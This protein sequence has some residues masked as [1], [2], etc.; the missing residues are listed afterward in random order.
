MLPPEL[1]RNKATVKCLFTRFKDTFFCEK[2][3]KG[4]L[5]TMPVFE[6]GVYS[7][8]MQT[9]HQVDPPG[10]LEGRLGGFDPAVTFT[11]TPE[12]E[13]NPYL[14]QVGMDSQANSSNIVLR[15]HD[16]VRNQMVA[17][18]HTGTSYLS[19]DTSSETGPDTK[20]RML[21]FS[22]MYYPFAQK[23]VSQ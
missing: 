2:I 20:P 3:R 17:R 14:V 18:I 16:A 19:T 8:D 12:N 5:L 1:Q 9:T 13:I 10:V 4:V 23:G 7:L 6:Q 21:C 22:F 15:V 11:V